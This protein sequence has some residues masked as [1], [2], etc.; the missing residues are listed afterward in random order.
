MQFCR[1]H[2]PVIVKEAGKDDYCSRCGSY[3][4][5]EHGSYTEAQ[6][7]ALALAAAKHFRNP[8]RNDPCPCGT[9]KKYKHCCMGKVERKPLPST[10]LC[11]E[12]RLNTPVSGG[13]AA[14]PYCR[15]CGKFYEPQYGSKPLP[16]NV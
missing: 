12:P 5:V 8:G 16:A 6:G 15:K 4:D 9:G 7:A 3:H 1:C 11:E 14:T 13:K 10:C 2:F